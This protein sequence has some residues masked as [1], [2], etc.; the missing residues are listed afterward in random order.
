MSERALPPST[1]AAERR[2]DSPWTLQ[3]LLNHRPWRVSLHGALFQP[4]YED[5]LLYN[6][7]PPV[8]PAI[9]V[10]MSSIAPSSKGQDMYRCFLHFSHEVTPHPESRFLLGNLLLDKLAVWKFWMSHKPRMTV[11][12]AT[13]E[14]QV[15]YT[16]TNMDLFPLCPK[17]AFWRSAVNQT[18]ADILADQ[19]IKAWSR[20]SST[21]VLHITLQD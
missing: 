15:L 11:T 1:V 8:L 9:E 4:Y 20:Y 12:I 14:G 7:S 16:V 5:R 19:F 10:T 13:P 2:H 18:I 3:D 21:F 6:R 17:R